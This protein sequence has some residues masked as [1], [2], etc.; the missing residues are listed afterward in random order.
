MPEKSANDGALLYSFTNS[1]H[2]EIPTWCSGEDVDHA[3]AG[4]GVVFDRFQLDLGVDVSDRGEV[5]SLS[6]VFRF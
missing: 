2:I 3:T 5:A 4:L 1:R 6:M